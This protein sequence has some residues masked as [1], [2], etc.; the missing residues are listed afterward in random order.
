VKILATTAL[1]RSFLVALLGTAAIGAALSP[2]VADVPKAPPAASPQPVNN[3]EVNR[4][5]LE[6]Q[7]ALKAGNAELAAIQIKNA[8]R[9]APKNGTVRAQLGLVMLA[10]G[11]TAS[12]EREL[13]QAMADGGPQPI[14]IPA[15]LQ[16]MMLRNEMKALLDEFPDPNAKDPYAQTVL[17]A[18]GIALAAL[19]Q[20][21]EANAAMDRALAIKRDTFS[22]VAR[23]QLARQQNDLDLAN[24]LV[25][26]AFTKTP[27]DAHIAVLKMELLRG[28]DDKRALAIADK[29]LA[30]QPDNLSLQLAR[31]E[32]LEDLDQDQE[33]MAQVDKILQKTPNLRV[34]VYY[35]ASVLAHQKNMRGAWL[36]A[37][38]LPPEFVQSDPAIAMTVAQMAL[39]NGNVETAAGI[40]ALL[41]SNHPEYV[42]ARLRLAV[43]RLRQNAPD[44]AVDLLLPL[45]D[46]K[47]PQVHALLSEAYM[48]QGKMSDALEE[49]QKANAANNGGAND[50]LYK[51][52]LALAEL[53]YGNTD[54]AITDLQKL[55]AQDPGSSELA[56]PLIAALLKAGKVDEALA[57]TEQ[58][59]KAA[60]K[61]AYPAFYRGQ[62]L[63]GKRDV[64]GAIAAFGTAL[65]LDP[66]FVPALFYRAQ[67]QEALNQTAAANQDLDRLLQVDPGNSPAL[68]MKAAILAAQT[69]KDP[70]AIALLN[71]AIAKSPKNTLAHMA[72]AKLLMLRGKYPDALAAINVW[73]KDI[74]DDPEGLAR[75][76]QV[77][78]ALGKKKDAEATFKTLTTKVPQSSAA[79]MLLAGA[80]STN[81]DTAGAKAAANQAIHLTPDSL[82]ARSQ[83]IALAFSQGD[84]QGAVASAKEMQSAHPSSEADLLLSETYLRMKN[85]SDAIAVLKQSLATRPDTRVLIRLCE[86][87]QATGDL[88]GAMALSANW[89][90]T[91]PNDMAVHRLHAGQLLA[92]G[93]QKG[94]GEE[95]EAVLKQYPD[96]AQSLNDLAWIIQD[97]D[98]KRA[99]A[100]ATRATQLAPQSAEI[101]DTLGWLQYRHGDVKSAV[102]LLQGA[103]KAA[104]DNPEIGYHLAVSLNAVGRRPE[105][106]SLLQQVMSKSPNFADAA[107]ARKLLTQW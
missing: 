62:I 89:L 20:T 93:D 85:T 43:L 57:A 105:A 39:G 42:P 95:Y 27:N 54:Q 23:A 19:G 59:A 91:H 28:H 25:D 48:K 77:Q 13:R 46:S 100:M 33:A 8:I 71:Q 50:L 29:M 21:A 90:S 84:T 45:S 2:A 63:L 65:D 10:M 49:L 69:G 5:L 74:P 82:Q 3:A 78:L 76:G 41:V 22:L 44:G 17:R 102:T 79:Q 66:K 80:L 81:G 7:K 107:D 60:P 16:A 11:D 4:L 51:R 36:L 75:L 18:R 34:A 64:K 98:P 99:I 55:A 32:V 53:R 68:V 61:S 38:G 67:A 26:E 94:A 14:I 92:T 70:Q 104:G 103:H 1:K 40:L 15:I 52:Q 72:L 24:K 58:M 86:L 6:A 30:A 106:K 9:M 83:F 35:K 37:Q 88:K 87:S 47:N 101:A 73:L 96:D 97:K 12:A 56:G 31:V